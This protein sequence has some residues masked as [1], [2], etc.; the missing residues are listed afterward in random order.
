MAKEIRNG[1]EVYVNTISDSPV[2]K[3][4]ERERTLISTTASFLSENIRGGKI[5]PAINRAE[6]SISLPDD[7]SMRRSFTVDLLENSILVCRERE[8]FIDKAVELAKKY[9]EA[10]LGKFFVIRP[11][12]SD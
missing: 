3:E 10:G 6:Y 12:K 2:D 1:I 4:S 9:E 7:P 8:D 11:Y 5:V